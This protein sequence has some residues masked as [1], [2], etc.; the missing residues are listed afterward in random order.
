MGTAGRY[1]EMPRPE[2]TGVPASLEAA[3]YLLEWVALVGAQATGGMMPPQVL[4]AQV[5]EFKALLP[6]RRLALVHSRLHCVDEQS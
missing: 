4:R 2:R 5:N 3:G 1:R 6:G